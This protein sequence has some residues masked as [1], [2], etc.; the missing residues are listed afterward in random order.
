MGSRG[1][2]LLDGVD[3]VGDGAEAVLVAG[4]D[5][6]KLDWAAKRPW[7]AKLGIGR[8]LGHARSAPSAQTK[9][10]LLG[11]L[12]DRSKPPSPSF[13]CGHNRGSRQRRLIVACNRSYSVDERFVGLATNADGSVVRALRRIYRQI[14][15]EREAP[16]EQALRR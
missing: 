12:R 15:S 8:G 11:E 7:A 3:G 5:L 16:L 14:R 13:H 10:P 4:L 6:H 1:G 2:R 9:E